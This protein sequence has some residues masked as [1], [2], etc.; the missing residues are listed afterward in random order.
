MRSTTGDSWA[1]RGVWSGELDEFEEAGG[2]GTPPVTS[3][4]MRTPPPA[5]KPKVVQARI[6][7]PAL[8]FPAVIAPRAQPPTSG[9][10]AIGN[11]TRCICLLVACDTS[12]LSKEDAA[13]YLRYVPWQQRGRRHLPAGGPGSFAET[14]L[15]VR[16]H[17]RRPMTTS[18]PRDLHG[19]LISF[20]G[21]RGNQNGITASLSDA[22][23][24]FYVQ[25][26]LKY[27]YEIR[28]SERRS[29]LLTDGCYHLF[30]NN[31]ATR[32]D[33]PS[34]EMALLLAR[35]AAP[36]RQQE[37]AAEWRVNR[38]FLLREYEFEY[39]YLHQP[40]QSGRVRTEVLHPVFVDRQAPST[41]RIG[42]ATDMH[43]S[44]HLDVYER[45]LQN[46]NFRNL[47]FNNW[48]RSFA[49]VYER[50]K[51]NTDVVLLTGDLIDY[52]RGHW[53]LN[54]ADRLGDDG[55]YHVDRNWF[56]FYHLLASGGAYTRPVYT[57]LGNHDWRLNPYTP[58]AVAGA[59][60]PSEF[61]HGMALP[62]TAQERE[63]QRA[64]IRAAH[65]KG[66]ER[67]V[68]YLSDVEKKWQLAFRKK[69]LWA[70]LKS[71]FGGSQTADIKGYPTETTVK[72]VEWYLQTINPFLDYWFARPSG[73]QVLMLDWAEDENVLFPETTNGRRHGL[74]IAWFVAGT[75]NADGPKARNCLTKLQ[76][77]LASQFAD[78]RFPAKV[79]G[80]H[81]PPIGPWSDWS[82]HELLGRVKRYP[83]GPKP[84]GNVGYSSKSRDGKTRQW[85]GHPLYAIRPAQEKS[86][87]PVFGM[88]A[89]YGSFESRRADFIKMVAN[90]G[91]GIRLVL[92]GHIH[93]NGL[94]SVY[95]GDKSRGALAGQ[96][97]IQAE[98]PQSVANIRPPMTSKRP[99]EQTPSGLRYPSGPLY[100]NT[101]S[102]GPRGN[103][104]VDAGNEQR[105]DPG[106]ARVHLAADGTIQQATFEAV[107]PAAIKATSTVPTRVPQTAPA[108]VP[109]GVP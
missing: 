46:S 107:S 54:R 106:L 19:E 27:L 87:D 62:R 79:I 56:L 98:I 57:I 14:D 69:S 39:G 72:S 82:D 32:E 76:W 53:G 97:L 24:G 64:P 50:A 48:N 93:R 17:E 73:Q 65:G 8:G 101:T 41:L 83:P 21:D 15:E 3:L 95:V 20:G 94:F 67:I 42:H 12:L 88:D 108:R 31:A 102:A 35:F 70:G 66:F 33:A 1:P 61:F 105:A 37:S 18:G 74:N 104:N 99:T 52:G 92:S 26:G 59:P 16:S 43:V 81:A 103:I 10:D 91:K 80:V 34:D 49:A 68:S 51:T 23:K 109:V 71:I 5:P 25:S 40:Y 75:P 2:S 9:E 38:E 45:N 47:H 78:A 11:A 89:S 55:S 6:L 22:V 30:W 100:V 85:N 7:W 29:G 86:S 96:W 36:R 77:W 84:R 44:T 28:V 63:Q 13:R 90:A 60:A 58:F 4:R